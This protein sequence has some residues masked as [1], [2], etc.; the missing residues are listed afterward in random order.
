MRRLTLSGGIRWDYV[1]G[2]IPA[3]SV[4]ANAFLPARNFAAVSNV[5]NWKDIDPR[6]GVAYDLFG[7]GKTALKAS[8]G[9]Y[10]VADA[11]TIA[12]A[13]NPQ[14]TF[15]NNTTRTW[16]SDPSGT[17]NPFNDCNLTNPAANG[18]C[19]AISNP[20]F[21]TQ[22]TPTTTYD[23]AIVTG[24]GVRPYNWEFQTS[25]QQQVAPRVSVYAGYARRWFG[26]FFATQNT[27]VTNASSTPYCV[28]IPTVPSVT[29]L[30]LPGAGGQQ[31][32]YFDL[33][34][35]TTA[36]S[37]IQAASNF[38]HVEDVFDAFDFDANAR[39]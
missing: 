20:G 8:I 23:P 9:R 12:R 19:G 32:G 16:T 11:Y 29:G 3:Q 21:G 4:P 6:L 35:P 25:I 7:N 39:L 27:A 34:R 1:K 28:G 24:W 15:I 33:I 31:C 5:P 37:L 30:S 14:S 13:V 17:F 2:S 38:G 36:I 10:V 26:N 18:S 22:A